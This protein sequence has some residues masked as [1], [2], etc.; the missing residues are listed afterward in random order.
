MLLYQIISGCLLLPLAF[1][2]SEGK[3]HV[4]RVLEISK[5]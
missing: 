1:M 3:L 4:S 2:R 5:I